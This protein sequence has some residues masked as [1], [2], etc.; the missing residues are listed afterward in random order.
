MGGEDLVDG[1][2]GHLRR[3]LGDEPASPWYVR[4]VRGIG[5]GM[6]DGS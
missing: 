3:K 2:V 1:D 6:G 4:T 5:Y